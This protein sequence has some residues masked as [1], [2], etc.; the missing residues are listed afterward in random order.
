[1]LFKGFQYC[2]GWI[3]RVIAFS[4]FILIST[5]VWRF[6]DILT[7]CNKNTSRSFC[8]DL[9]QCFQKQK[10]H[11]N[12]TFSRFEAFAAFSGTK[13]SHEGR[14]IISKAFVAYK[15]LLV[16]VVKFVKSTIFDFFTKPS[17]VYRKLY[18][19]LCERK[20]DLRGQ[21]QTYRRLTQQLDPVKQGKR[22]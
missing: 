11:E 3:C 21:T 1:M 17:Y 14:F 8:Y 15:Y 10:G 13:K 9:F 18:T 2:F 22:I 6:I 5:Y 12:S 19:F 16:Y 4:N 7:L 20:E